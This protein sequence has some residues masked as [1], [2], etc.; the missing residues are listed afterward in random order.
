MI[1]DKRCF[2]IYGYDVLLDS[3]LKPW[4]MEVNASPSLTADVPTDYCLK[5]GLLE[6]AMCIVDM[7]KL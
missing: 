5:M 3:N 6:D 4:L 7:E 2:E 1:N